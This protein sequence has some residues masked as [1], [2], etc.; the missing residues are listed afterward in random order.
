LEKLQ[1]DLSK[2]RQVS[3]AFKTIVEAYHDLVWQVIS[4]KC[5]TFKP[6]NLHMLSS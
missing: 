4:D 1:C 3:S 6:L 2:V 5:Y